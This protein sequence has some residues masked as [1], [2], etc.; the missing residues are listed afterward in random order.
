MLAAGI[1]GSLIYELTPKP[2]VAIFY[3]FGIY[4]YVLYYNITRIENSLNV[5]H[6]KG[7]KVLSSSNERTLK[8][9][10]LHWEKEGFIQ[11]NTKN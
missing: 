1:I 8:L 10:K 7:W 11:R 3:Y 6:N 5:L 4:V 9:A 2:E